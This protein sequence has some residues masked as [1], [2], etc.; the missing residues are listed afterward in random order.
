[1]SDDKDFKKVLTWLGIAVL[2]AIP[3]VIALK[4]LANETVDPTEAV[5]DE[6]FD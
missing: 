1:M 5:L 6:I 3:L 4:K 2:A